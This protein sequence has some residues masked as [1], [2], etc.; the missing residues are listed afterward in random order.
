MRQ[1]LYPIATSRLII[2]ILFDHNLS[3]GHR[4]L[5]HRDAMV[6]NTAGVPPQHVESKSI[7]V[8]SRSLTPLLPRPAHPSFYVPVK[9]FI[10]IFPTYKLSSK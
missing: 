8:T 3:T 6:L 10:S 7:H 5:R 4:L 9:R 1:Y 2:S